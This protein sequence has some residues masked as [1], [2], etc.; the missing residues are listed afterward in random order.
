MF[1]SLTKSLLHLGAFASWRLGGEMVD[2]EIRNLK[3]ETR[4]PCLE[5]Y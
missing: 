2:A 1:K 4:N 3:P 5:L